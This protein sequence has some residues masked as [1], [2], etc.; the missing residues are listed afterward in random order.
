MEEILVERHGGAVFFEM[1]CNVFFF[2]TVQR[3]VGRSF[4]L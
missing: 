4:R 2:F 1:G 3:W